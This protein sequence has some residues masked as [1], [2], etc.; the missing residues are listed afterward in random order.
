MYALRKKY[1]LSA[2]DVST[3]RVEVWIRGT[4]ELIA[5]GFAPEFAGEMSAK[6]V[7]KSYGRE[8]KIKGIGLKEVLES[9]EAEVAD[10]VE[11][12][13]EPHDERREHTRRTARSPI[14]VCSKEGSWPGQIINFSRH[15][16][17]INSS[18]LLEVGEDLA[19]ILQSPS[20]SRVE[21]L[22]GVVKRS[23]RSVGD[24]G[25]H[26]YGVELKG[27]L[28]SLSSSQDGGPGGMGTTME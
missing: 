21:A 16:L 13:E 3:P 15:G 4:R 8:R 12:V 7:F 24:E 22:K 25:L 5:T 11:P 1:G 17:Y 19:C 20:L 6:R 23:V 10:K 14:M 2:E 18:A 28:E 26:F 27:A 9:A